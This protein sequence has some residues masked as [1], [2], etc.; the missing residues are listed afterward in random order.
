MSKKYFYLTRDTII[1]GTLHKAYKSQTIKSSFLPVLE[2][3]EAQG[4]A[5]LTPAQVVPDVTSKTAVIK[6]AK[7]APAKKISSKE[8][9]KEE[10]E[11]L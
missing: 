6:K 7:P 3:L 1:E 2:Q 9:V 5:I 4:V 11:T 10:G 8:V